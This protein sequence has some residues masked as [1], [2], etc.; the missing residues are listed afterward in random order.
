VNIYLLSKWKIWLQGRYFWLRCFVSSAI[1]E[2]IVTIIADITAFWGTMSLTQFDHLVLSVYFFKVLYSL[3]ATFPASWVT[4]FL[5]KYEGI[6]VYDY[7]TK[8]NPFSLKL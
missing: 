5:K 4:T 1:G 3:I 6:D 8:F 2:I 7:T